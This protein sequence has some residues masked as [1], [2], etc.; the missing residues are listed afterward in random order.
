MQI[1]IIL[2]SRQNWLNLGLIQLPWPSSISSRCVLIVRSFIYLQNRFSH[3]RPILFIVQLFLL[4]LINQ[5]YRIILSSYQAAQCITTLKITSGGI[6]PPIVLIHSIIVTHSRLPGCIILGRP[7]LL[8]LV[9]T[10][11]VAITPIWKPVLLK[12]QVSL[13]RILY[14]IFIS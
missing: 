6:I 7:A 12:F 10:L 9:T 4:I 2:Q 5:L 1:T 3:V 8:V 11:V 14:S 13:S